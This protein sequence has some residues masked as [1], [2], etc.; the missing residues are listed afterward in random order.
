MMQSDINLQWIKDKIV[1]GTLFPR[2]QRF[3]RND[4]SNSNTSINSAPVSANSTPISTPIHRGTNN[5]SFRPSS[6]MNTRNGHYSNQN[7]AQARTPQLLSYSNRQNS[8]PG[9][10]LKQFT[11]LNNDSQQ[12]IHAVNNRLSAKSNSTITINGNIGANSRPSGSLRRRRF[13][14]QYQ[15]RL[16]RRL[17]RQTSSGTSLSTSQEYSTSG[18]SIPANP[19]IDRL[20]DYIQNN[21]IK[22]MEQIPFDIDRKIRLTSFGNYQLDSSIF[23]RKVRVELK[24]GKNNLY[25]SISN[26]LTVCLLFIILFFLDFSMQTNFSIQSIFDDN[27]NFFGNKMKNEASFRMDSGRIYGASNFERIGDSKL[28]KAQEELAQI[29]LAT[30]I[31]F[32]DQLIDILFSA[33]FLKF[34]M[35]DK[36][37]RIFIEKFIIYIELAID[38]TMSAKVKVLRLVS[39]DG[40]EC[41]TRGIPFPLNKTIDSFA[42]KTIH[43]MAANSE[44]YMDQIQLILNQF[45][46]NLVEH[47]LKSLNIL[48]LFW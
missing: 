1:L 35:R 6:A 48:D 36:H 20:I 21:Y 27:G 43:T 40:V 41:K 12:T 17:S 14:Q 31:L 29:I 3:S 2:H 26:L 7:R 33:K 5:G 39:I 24:M 11:N 46:D 44:Q 22:Q 32:T 15:A 4:S 23:A 16:D 47:S 34:L 18:S 13:K 42:L 10:K 37:L 45:C 28:I 30:N 38:Q 25:S 9:T 19:I 8:F